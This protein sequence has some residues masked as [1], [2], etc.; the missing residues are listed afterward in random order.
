MRITGYG[1]GLGF[2]VS[3]NPLFQ[4]EFKHLKEMCSRRVLGRRVG[5]HDPLQL[6]DFFS[7]VVVFERY[8]ERR[9]I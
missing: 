5:C 4:L 7:T 6:C 9:R 1:Y 2:K 8:N 3:V